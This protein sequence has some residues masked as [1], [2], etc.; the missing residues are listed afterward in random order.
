[1]AAGTTAGQDLNLSLDRVVGGRNL[2]NKL[3]NAGKF[4]QMAL[5]NRT[6]EET[7]ALARADFSAPAALAGLPLTERWVVSALH[8]VRGARVAWPRAAPCQL[9]ALRFGAAIHASAPSCL[10]CCSW[11]QVAAAMCCARTTLSRLCARQ[12]AGKS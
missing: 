10:P 9:A 1:V 6:A 2:T 5:D 12:E 4:L 3:W 7:A 11:L 8:Q